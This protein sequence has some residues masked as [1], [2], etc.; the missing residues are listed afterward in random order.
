MGGAIGGAGAGAALLFG[1]RAIVLRNEKGAVLALSGRQV[2][3]IANADLSG[4]AISLR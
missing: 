3:L 4:L 1:A 2:G